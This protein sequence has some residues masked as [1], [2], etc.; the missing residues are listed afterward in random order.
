[1]S[2]KCLVT[3]GDRNA[4]ITFDE[5]W[6]GRD[7]MEHIKELD[8]FSEVDVSTIGLTDPI[9]THHVPTVTYNGSLLTSREFTMRLE[10]LD[11]KE[12]GLLAAIA[13]QIALY[14]A[15]N[16]VFGKKAQRTFDLLCQVLKVQ[17]VLRPTSLVRVAL[18]ILSQ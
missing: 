3:Y 14:W 12:T 16:I 5:P 6:M 2:S 11:I 10:G 1:M 8:M 7:S 15:L 17:S 4:V 13:T 9:K 18:T